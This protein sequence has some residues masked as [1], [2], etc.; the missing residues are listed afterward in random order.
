MEINAFCSVT[1]LQCAINIHLQ[2]LLTP[3]SAVLRDNDG[4]TVLHTAA[5]KGKVSENTWP[6]EL[7]FNPVNIIQLQSVEYK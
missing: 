1:D 6:L 3:Q 2:A 4:K 5:E 7:M